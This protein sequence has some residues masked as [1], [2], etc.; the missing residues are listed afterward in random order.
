MTTSRAPRRRNEDQQHRTFQ[1]IRIGD[2]TR[3]FGHRYGGSALYQLPDDDSGREDARI[4]LDH[5]SYA[6]PAA[7]ARVLKA[8]APW[9]IGTER[10]DLLQEV[11]R[12]PR[13]W[14]AEALAA[15]LNLTEVDRRKLKIRTIGAVDMTAEERKQQ[16]KLR[17][18]ARKRLRR[19]S[20]GAKKREQYLADSKSR[21]KP[22]KAAGV[23]RRTWY[24]RAKGSAADGPVPRGTSV[25]AIKLKLLSSGRTCATE[26]AAKSQRE[27][28]ENIP[29]GPA[30]PLSQRLP[31]GS[32]Q[33]M[34]VS[35]CYATG[36]VTLSRKELASFIKI[37]DA[38]ADDA[39]GS[40]F[41]TIADLESV[42]DWQNTWTT[43][44]QIKAFVSLG[45]INRD[46]DCVLVSDAGQRV[47]ELSSNDDQ[48]AKAA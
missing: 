45:L 30:T 46:G 5:Y 41:K 13:R 17:E 44:F 18:R 6:N 39:Y 22:W 2:L 42:I 32:N 25:S 34:N 27:S 12:F 1:S 21:L 8:R 19:R 11:T 40:G 4:L 9:L 31:R 14:T 10:D 16:R 28:H 36:P 37:A 43:Q 38:I 47:R 35:E 23:S 3:L 20:G 15:K 26:Q 7:I 48:P 33:N 29:K 24:R